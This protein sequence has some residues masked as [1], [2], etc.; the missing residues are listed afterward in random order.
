[1][2]TKLLLLGLSAALLGGHLTLAASRPAAAIVA[3]KVAVD[4]D[5]DRLRTQDRAL[6]D[7]LRALQAGE[8]GN[9][10]AV[11]APGGLVEGVELLG[12]R[13]GAPA[14]TTRW[15]AARENLIAANRQLAP[16]SIKFNQEAERLLAASSAEAKPNRENISVAKSAVSDAESQVQTAVADGKPEKVAN[17]KAQL[18]DAKARLASAV[19]VDQARF[20]KYTDLIKQN[21]AAWSNYWDQGMAATVAESEAASREIDRLVAE[22]RLNT[23]Q[24]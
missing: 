1:M 10:A 20:K 19:A 11:Q 4:N 9:V 17:A 6:D 2:K 13:S 3:D 23:V 5:L 16:G 12:I 14:I 15:L 24:P 22:R 8:V 21:R 18:A 7:E